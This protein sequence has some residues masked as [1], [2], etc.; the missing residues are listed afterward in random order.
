M[1]VDKPG[2]CSIAFLLSCIPAPYPSSLTNPH[3][4]PIRLHTHAHSQNVNC[5]SLPLAPR[6]TTK[7]LLKVI[8]KASSAKHVRR[9]VKEVVKAVRKSEKGLAVLAGDVYPIDVVSHLPVMLEEAE[10]PYV[11]VPS[12]AMLGMSASTKRPTSIVLVN[13]KEG[14]DAMELYEECLGAVKGM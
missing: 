14:F 1:G 2:D 10:I 8:K 9:G 12:K 3:A 4:P 7:K 13:P 11:F 6:K 5:I